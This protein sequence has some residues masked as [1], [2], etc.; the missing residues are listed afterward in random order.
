MYFQLTNLWSVQCGRGHV[1]AGTVVDTS[2][3]EWAFLRNIGPPPDA[4]ALDQSTYEYMVRDLGYSVFNTRIG[5]D[6]K[7]LAPPYKLTDWD[8]L[9]RQR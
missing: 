1:E 2:R 8:E 6:V 5:P 3:Q 7:S 4:I 9:W